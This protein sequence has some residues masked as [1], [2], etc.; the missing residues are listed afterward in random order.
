MAKELA[1]KLMN[2]RL[3]LTCKIIP[4]LCENV[5]PGSHTSYMLERSVALRFGAWMLRIDG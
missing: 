1:R 3:E 4:V 5:S 2:G